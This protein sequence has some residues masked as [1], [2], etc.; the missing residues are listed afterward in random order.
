MSED[1]EEKTS[2]DPCG[3]GDLFLIQKRKQARDKDLEVIS[4]K[5]VTEVMKVQEIIQGKSV[6]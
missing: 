1:P 6:K 4:T 3:A 5:A 2:A